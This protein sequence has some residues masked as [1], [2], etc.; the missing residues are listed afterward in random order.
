MLH[1]KW[2]QSWLILLHLTYHF[3]RLPSQTNNYQY[4]AL[5]SPKINCFLMEA[6][7]AGLSFLDLT[8]SMNLLLF[9]HKS[10]LHSSC[11]SP[12]SYLS[13]GV[14]SFVEI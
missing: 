4:T 14:P 8:A 13:N 9:V 3:G 1:I 6:S 7:T 11:F 5:S 12:G 2:F 10:E